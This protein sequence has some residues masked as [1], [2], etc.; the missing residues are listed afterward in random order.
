MYII[1]FCFFVYRKQKDVVCVINL[2]MLYEQR[3]L[4]QNNNQN[5]KNQQLQQQ[6]QGNLI[7]LGENSDEDNNDDLIH[8]DQEEEQ[9]NLNSQNFQEIFELQQQLQLNNIN[10]SFES[11]QQQKQIQNN[12]QQFFLV[13]DELPIQPQTT[14]KKNSNDV[15]NNSQLEKLDSVD[16]TKKLQGVKKYDMFDDLFLE[17]KMTM[18]NEVK[19]RN[20]HMGNQE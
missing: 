12:Q 5:Q 2:L 17:Q 9:N 7:E 6:F 14:N 11:S 13:E 16:Q 1:Q 3:E 19:F 4:N 20:K 8:V 18:K 15:V 10:I